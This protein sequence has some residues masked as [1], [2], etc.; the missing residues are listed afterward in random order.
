MLFLFYLPILPMSGQA[1]YWSM[2]LVLFAMV[3]TDFNVVYWDEAPMLLY[4]DY[5][6]ENNNM[7][8]NYIGIILIFNV[9]YPNTNNIGASSQYTFVNVKSSPYIEANK[10]Q[11]IDQ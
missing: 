3:W 10:T 6:N 9:L 5:T 7:L 8:Y 4:L 11:I 1:F 2:I